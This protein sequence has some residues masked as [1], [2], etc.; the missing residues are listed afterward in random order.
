MLRVLITDKR[1]AVVD[2]DDFIFD[3]D[4]VNLFNGDDIVAMFDSGA[5]IGVYKPIPSEVVIKNAVSRK[6]YTLT[7]VEKL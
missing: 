3:D 6:P 2:A 5:V 1:E 7:E 4:F